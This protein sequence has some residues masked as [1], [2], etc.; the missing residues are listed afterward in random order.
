MNGHP[1]SQYMFLLSDKKPDIERVTGYTF[2]I[3]E[4]SP[5]P[6]K[7]WSLTWHDLVRFPNTLPLPCL[8]M[9]PLMLEQ[10]DQNQ[11]VLQRILG[12]E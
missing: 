10:N 1:I 3:I 8:D 2:V 6:D 9:T 11:P 4:G 12:Q 7:K 5:R